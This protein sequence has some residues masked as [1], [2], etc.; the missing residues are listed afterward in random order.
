MPVNQILY[1]ETPCIQGLILLAKE[2]LKLTKPFSVFVFFEY[3]PFGPDYPLNSTCGED[4]GI[5][6]P[7]S[8][9]SSLSGAPPTGVHW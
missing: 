9:G 1:T 3:F 2:P 4:P 5:D 8:Y 7:S 6:S